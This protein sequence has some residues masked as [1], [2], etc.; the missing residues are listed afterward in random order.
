VNTKLTN[1]FSTNSW[2][3]T[4]KNNGYLSFEVVQGVC[5][6]YKKQANSFT[7]SYK[8]KGLRK[9]GHLHWQRSTLINACT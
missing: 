5:T 6:S 7:G 9:G 4:K 3:C 8:E 1:R 2:V